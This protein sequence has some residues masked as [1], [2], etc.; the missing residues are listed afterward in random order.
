MALD[1]LPPLGC[2]GVGDSDLVSQ[3]RELSRWLKACE[4][5]AHIVHLNYHAS[6]GNFLSVHL[7]LKERYEAHL[8]DF[9]TAAE[10]VRAL[11]VRFIDTVSELHRVPD[12]FSDLLPECGCSESLA[13][14][15]SNLQQLIAMAQTLE[16]IAQKARAIDVANWCAEL[17]ASSSKACWFLRATLGC[18]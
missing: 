9:D 12:G 16:P 17:V 14:Y 8:E 3:L 13:T 5:Q 7:F 10:F 4:A 11:G 18:V 2:N 15:F 6:E 1:T